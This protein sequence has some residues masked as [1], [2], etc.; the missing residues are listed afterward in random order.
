MNKFLV[1]TIL[2]AV[3]SAALAEETAPEC[4]AAAE[5]M[6]QTMAE[7]S[8]GFRESLTTAKA[9]ATVTKT[10]ANLQAENACGL[11]LVLPDSSLRALARQGGAS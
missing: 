5:R 6:L 9:V 8:P 10:A 2:T 11:M 1:A 7:E 4:I 3:S